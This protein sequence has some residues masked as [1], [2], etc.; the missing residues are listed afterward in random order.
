MVLCNIAVQC[1]QVEEKIV[2]K[3]IVYFL[4]GIVVIVAGLFAAVAFLVN[5]NDYKEDIISLVKDQT[6]RELTIKQD[7][8]LT[9][10][11]WIGVKLG[12]V[13]L[14]N[15]TG[16]GSAPF[17]GVELLN[18]RVKLMPLF[19]KRL[20]AD[21][22]SVKG[23]HLNL[24]KNAAGISNW[25]DLTTANAEKAPVETTTTEG[26]DSSSNHPPAVAL[27]IG[28]LEI[29]N[30]ALNWR[31]DVAGVTYNVKDVNL[32][33]G[34]LSPG[35]PFDIKLDFGLNSSEPPMTAKIA[36]SGQATLDLVAQI[37]QFSSGTLKINAQ[38]EAVPE[39]K[40]ELTLNFDATA[41]LGN[42]T[43]SV[44]GLKLSALGINATGNISGTS[45]VSNPRFKTKL[46]LSEFDLKELLAKVAGQNIETR[47]PKAMQKFSAQVTVLAGLNEAKITN[48]RT[49]LDDTTLRGTASMSNFQNQQ[50][51]LIWH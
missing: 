19:G 6:G 42:E 2:V 13:E 31:D 48:L 12:G 46:S 40:T 3:T 35:E 21:S 27:A 5:P 18:V 22:I 44:K 47:D 16:F 34:K 26:D 9:F 38:G 30:A 4:G 43:M 17:V 39:G 10:F 50:F 51:V 36:F 37:Y 15:A 24:A 32:S 29:E 33:T 8:A 20:E 45:I 28:G 41:D 14:S 11:P 7:M 49:H 25:D 1:L 23:L